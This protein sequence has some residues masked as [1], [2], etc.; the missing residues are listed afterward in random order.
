MKIA[1][2]LL[3]EF[4]EIQPIKMGK[5]SIQHSN[6]HFLN[7]LPPFKIFDTVDSGPNPF[8]GK[9]IFCEK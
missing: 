4:L 3:K 6:P 8:W 9:S 2:K 5:N 7:I 1:R